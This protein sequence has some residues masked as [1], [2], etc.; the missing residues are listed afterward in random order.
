MR[1]IMQKT[2]ELQEE[3]YKLSQDLLNIQAQAT[4]PGQQHVDTD[5]PI[6]KTLALLTR[7]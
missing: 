2:E 4:T 3:N 5:T 1:D 7:I 6:D